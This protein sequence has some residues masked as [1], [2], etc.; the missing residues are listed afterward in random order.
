VLVESLS[1][2]IRNEFLS[3]A[4]NNP[5]FT[6]KETEEVLAELSPQE[7]RKMSAILEQN[8]TLPP[9]LKNLFSKMAQLKQT[10]IQKEEKKEQGPYLDDFEL[11]G[12]VTQYFGD[13]NFKSYI[14]KGYEKTLEKLFYTKYKRDKGI[15]R[16]VQ[17]S[18]YD[19]VVDTSY[20]SSMLEVI[21]SG[22]IRSQ[23]S[24]DLLTKL[25]DLTLLYLETGRFDNVL[26][27][28]NTI[29]SLMLKGS[30]KNETQSMIEYFF[31]S[32]K[33]ISEFADAVRIW[34]RLKRDDTLKL[35]R[36]M[37]NYV[38]V[39]LIDILCSEENSATRKFLIIIIGRLGKDALEEAVKRLDDERWYVVRNMIYLLRESGKEEYA[40]NIAPLV[41]HNNIQVKTEALRTLLRFGIPEGPDHAIT[42]LQ[43]RDPKLKEEAI[44][45]SG[46]FRIKA[47]QPFLVD[48][49]MKRD[50]LQARFQC[51]VAAI[52]ALG[53]MGD[54]SVL[55]VFQ[56]LFHSDSIIYKGAYDTFKKEIL[57]STIHFKLNDVKPFL[58]MALQSE[59][60]EMRGIAEKILAGKKHD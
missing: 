29:Y 47:A 27:I 32:E 15:A 4:V 39:P 24:L 38:T 31:H 6:Q 30:F 10:F 20:C 46:I 21:N 22:N 58:Q 40:E 11:I 5:I 41:H 49:L 34:G 16:E 50:L 57:N 60:D 44:R 26:Y 37:K 54:P 33:F 59:D 13:H 35:A 9:S 19:D 42:F 36:V 14:D 51:R 28:Y 8:T 48:I 3:A 55:E 52:R 53:R 7:L 1:P 56:K 12:E 2:E 25:S 43:S 23:D 45:L 18:L 17:K